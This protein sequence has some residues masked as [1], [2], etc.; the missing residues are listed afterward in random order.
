[1]RIAIRGHNLPGAGFPCLSAGEVRE[2][3]HVAVQEG[4]EPVGLVRGDARG[5]AWDVDVRVLETEDGLDF[6]GQAVHGKRGERFVYLT[7]GTVGDDG[8]FAMFRRAKLMLGRVD[9]AL[10]RAADAA[11]TPLVAEV[12][13]TDER[14]G[15][16]CARVDPP[17]LR[18][19]LGQ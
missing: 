4:R 1:M 7:W 16:R 8:S 2:N 18:W 15:P 5:A 9:P 6:R 17:A 14:G 11:G 19:S 3:V 12:D 13:L 10:V